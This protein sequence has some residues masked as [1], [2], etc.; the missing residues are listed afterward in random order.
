M[1]VLNLVNLAMMLSM[2]VMMIPII[3]ILEIMFLW[4]LYDYLHSCYDQCYFLDTP[5]LL[6]ITMMTDDGDR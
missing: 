3:V 6:L 5:M 4:L 1:I 2:M